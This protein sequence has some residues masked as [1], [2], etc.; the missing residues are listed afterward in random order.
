MDR[1][2][3]LFA[4]ALLVAALPPGARAAD[5]PPG[6]PPAAPTAALE[7]IDDASAGEHVGEECVVEMVVRAARALADK[8]MC[9][10]NSRQ[11]RHDEENFTA[12]IFADG[13]TRFREAGVENPALHFLDRRIRV[14][15]V[16]AE[17]KERPQ[18]VVDDPGQ[19]EIVAE[20]DEPDEDDPAEDQDE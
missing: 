13:L 18:I 20:P 2:A 14:R 10:L 8:E 12:V 17:H 7:P 4:V 11:D 19:I 16:I 15:G 9:F 6:E 1:A 3:R 5:A